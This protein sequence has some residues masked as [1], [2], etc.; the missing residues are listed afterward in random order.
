MFS[1]AVTAADRSRS[2]S[3]TAATNC[4]VSASFGFFAATL[5]RVCSAP[6]IL[7]DYA[8]PVPENG[9]I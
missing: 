2:R 1:A 4:L 7:A 5:A 8:P 9:P 3:V 6:T